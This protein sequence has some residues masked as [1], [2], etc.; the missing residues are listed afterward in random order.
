MLP[1]NPHAA[2][3]TPSHRIREVLIAVEGRVQQSELGT[4]SHVSTNTYAP[5]YGM[6]ARGEDVSI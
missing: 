3:D 2:S 6:I 1:V 4:T 5:R